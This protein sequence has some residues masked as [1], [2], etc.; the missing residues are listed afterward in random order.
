MLKSRDNTVT[1]IAGVDVKGDEQS[2][3]SRIRMQL[4]RSM[5]RKYEEVLC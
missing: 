2:Y 4:E 5:E 1:M 3:L